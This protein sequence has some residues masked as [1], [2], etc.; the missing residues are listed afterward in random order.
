MKA[1][2][3]DHHGK[4]DA[5]RYGERPDPAAGAGEVVVRLEAAAMNRLDLFVL[6]GIPGVPPSLPH[7]PGADGTGRVESV[8]AGV[9]DL[10]PGERVVLQPGI[11]C[12]RCEFCLAGELSLCVDFKILG[13]HLLGTFAER[14]AV[15]R[16]NVFPAPPNLLPEKAAAFPLAALT[17]WRMLVTRAQI[18]PGE[19]V[20]IHGIGGGVSTFAL[21]IA[22]LAGASLV[23]VT[24]SS[25]EKRK[26]A[27]A[28]GADVV[29][30][31]TQVDVGKKVREITKKRGVDVVVDSVGAATWRAS[32][33]AAAK[34]GRIVTCGATS[35]PNPEEE[36]RLIFWKQLSI[37]GSTM[38]T[39]AEFSALL[40]AVSAGRVTPIVDSVFPLAEGR[41]AYE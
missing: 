26:K 6:H 38:G 5:L 9:T 31:Y 4:S 25:E 2:F 19:T 23:I 13:E 29:L 3:F 12:G 11:G 32:L 33:S 24:S 30:D 36:I 27:E 10:A 35:G 41:K 7:I 28:L 40:A 22:R 16:R 21:Q 20:L 39:D 17:A 1:L 15:P 18:R 8:G 34:K 37:L 14:I